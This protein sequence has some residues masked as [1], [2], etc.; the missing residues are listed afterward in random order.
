MPEDTRLLTTDEASRYLGLRSQL[1]VQWR[2]EH[3]G[4]AFHRLG[5]RL[6]RYDIAELDAWLEDQRVAPGA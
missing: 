2:Y 3:K 6:V 5:G 1:L 4:P